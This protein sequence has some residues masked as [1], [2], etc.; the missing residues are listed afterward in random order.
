M[1]L[2]HRSEISPRR[3]AAK[4]KPRQAWKNIR[5]GGKNRSVRNVFRPPPEHQCCDNQTSCLLHYSI[6]TVVFGYITLLITVENAYF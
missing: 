4:L 5:L 3:Q 6:I 1:C 2:S